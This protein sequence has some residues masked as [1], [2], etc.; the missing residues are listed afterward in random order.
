MKRG[1]E[2]KWRPGPALWKKIEPLARQKRLEPT[3]AEAC[4]WASLWDRQVLG[5]KFRRQH[6]IGKFIV[7]FYC[8]AAHLIIEV[9]GPIHEYSVEEDAIRQEYLESLSFRVIRFTNEDVLGEIEAVIKR[10]GAALQPS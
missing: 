7:D 10:I 8:L 4:L 2:Q 9:D 1:I 3:P 5:H 6:A